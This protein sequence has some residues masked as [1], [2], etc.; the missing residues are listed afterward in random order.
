MMDRIE[1]ITSVE[2]RRR[3]SASEKERWVEALREPGA[4]VS[5]IARRAGVSASYL[6]RWRR[7]LE[8]AGKSS[9]FVPVTIAAPESGCVAGPAMITVEFACGARMRIE[10]APDGERLT[11]VVGALSGSTRRAAG[12]ERGER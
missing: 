7:E 10:G 11:R 3:W 6:Y 1:V 5:A 9:P 8:D 12:A 4:N 2:R